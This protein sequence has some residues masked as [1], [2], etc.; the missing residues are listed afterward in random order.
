MINL[1]S[2]I[3]VMCNK[4]FQKSCVWDCWHFACSQDL[5]NVECWF[6]SFFHA[7]DFRTLLKRQQK[8]AEEAEAETKQ[9]LRGSFRLKVKGHRRGR[10]D[11]T[12]FIK[13]KYNR[14]PDAFN[15]SNNLLRQMST[16]S[17]KYRF[18]MYSQTQGL[19][20]VLECSHLSSNSFQVFQGIIVIVN[21]VF[22]TKAMQ[23]KRIKK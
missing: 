1:N 23:K 11:G 21:I 2:P 22:P 5:T 17:G 12:I 6:S 15:V 7:G 19:I 8:E 16:S 20:F 14:M 10:S 9:S 3:L 4:T 13:E 18:S